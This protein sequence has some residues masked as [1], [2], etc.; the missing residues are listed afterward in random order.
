MEKSKFI[1]IILL[2][3]VSLNICTLSYLFIQNNKKAGHFPPPPPPK[4]M[5]MGPERAKK[6][7]IE[8]LDLD[9]HQIIIFDELEEKHRAELDQVD[10][11]RDDQKRELYGLLMK[12][13]TTGLTMKS[14]SLLEVISKTIKK[15]EKAHFDFFVGLRQA[16]KPA[17]KVKF[18][19]LADTISKLFSPKPP[20]RNKR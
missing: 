7:F 9:E 4:G 1:L 6:M 3:L 20:P 18:D 15:A 8:K 14:D 2:F 5:G 16:L 19:Q 13:D 12:N 11:V 10:A 17:Q